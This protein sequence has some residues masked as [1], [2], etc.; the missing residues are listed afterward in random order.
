[1]QGHDMNILPA[2]KKGY[3]G[4]DVV[5][6]ILDDGMFAARLSFT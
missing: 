5:I 2:W 6:T 3:T 4:K 1:M